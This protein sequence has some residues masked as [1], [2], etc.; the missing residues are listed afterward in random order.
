MTD[1]KEFEASGASG[2]AAACHG[3]NIIHP[4]DLE[5]AQEK[6]LRYRSIRIGQLTMFIFATGFSIILT[7]VYPYMQEV[8]EVGS[9]GSCSAAQT[10]SAKM[11]DRCAKPLKTQGTTLDY[12]QRAAGAA[13]QK[14]NGGRTARCKKS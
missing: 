8:S 1:N 3:S 6:K 2:S 9:L 14:G 12:L 13:A 11:P 7:G 5:T 4:Q 10:Q